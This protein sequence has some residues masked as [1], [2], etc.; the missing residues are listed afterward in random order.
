VEPLRKKMKKVDR[1]YRKDQAMAEPLKPLN[2]VHSGEIGESAYQYQ[3]EI[4]TKKRLLL[5]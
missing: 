2:Q 5:D 4:E 3:K 1:I